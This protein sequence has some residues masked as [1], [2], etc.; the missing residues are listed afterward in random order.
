MEYDTDC[1]EAVLLLSRERWVWDCVE[2]ME[3]EKRNES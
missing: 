3:I 1:S 2:A